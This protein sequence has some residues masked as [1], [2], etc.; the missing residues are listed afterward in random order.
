MHGELLR[1]G[2]HQALARSLLISLYRHLLLLSSAVCRCGV[3]LAELQAS[4]TFQWLAQA[5]VTLVSAVR[6]VALAFV[7]WASSDAVESAAISTEPRKCHP[8]NRA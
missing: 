8:G 6:F 5:D 2:L 4:R 7:L 3:R 1:L